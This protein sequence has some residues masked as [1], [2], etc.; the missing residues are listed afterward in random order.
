MYIVRANGSR[1]VSA[2]GPSGEVGKFANVD[3]DGDLIELVDYDGNKS[4]YAANMFELTVENDVKNE[5]IP[6]VEEVIQ[7]K[8]CYTFEKQF[9]PNKDW[10]PPAKS[11]EEQ[12]AENEAKVAYLATMLDME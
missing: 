3:F 11:I 7:G 5:D 6:P 12:A 1:V 10:R 2:I 9:Y 4:Y 8:W